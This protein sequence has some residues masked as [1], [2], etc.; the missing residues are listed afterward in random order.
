MDYEQFACQ[1]D[2]KQIT[3]HTM[4]IHHRDVIPKQGVEINKHILVHIILKFKREQP[5]LV[6]LF[7][8][9]GSTNNSILSVTLVL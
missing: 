3:S 4:L 8:I 1:V 9:T 7:M 2:I 6:K 5:I